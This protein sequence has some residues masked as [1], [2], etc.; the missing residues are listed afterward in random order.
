[1]VPDE[2]YHHTILCNS[3]FRISPNNW[4][5][6]DWSHNQ[7]RT[8]HPKTLLMEDLAKIRELT[9][10]FA[11][12]FDADVDQEVLDALDEDVMR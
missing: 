1:M 9:A 4:R 10:H 6:T 5:Y 12:K 2:L 8:P 3:N 11:R 7:G